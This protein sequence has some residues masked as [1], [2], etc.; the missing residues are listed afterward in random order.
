MVDVKNQYGNSKNKKL[1]SDLRNKLKHSVTCWY[2]RERTQWGKRTPH[3]V[4]E[5]RKETSW[6]TRRNKY[7]I[8]PVGLASP[9]PHQ[10]HFISV[11][12]LPTNNPPRRSGDYPQETLYP[13][14]KNQKPGIFAVSSLDLIL[15]WRLRRNDL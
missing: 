4:S 6:I 9:K 11:I 7:H 5:I 2:E 14:K 15:F 13:P 10:C 8:R 3:S 12:I 1:K